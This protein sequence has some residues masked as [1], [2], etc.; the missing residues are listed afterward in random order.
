VLQ[1]QGGDLAAAS[2]S[3]RAVLALDP[4]SVM[5]RN[6]LGAVLRDLGQLDDAMTLFREALALDPAAV[7]AHNN[8]GAALRLRGNLEGAV[9]EF[10]TAL[11]LDPVNAVAL[12]NLSE[13]L[14]DLG[15]DGAAL[16]AQHRAVAAAPSDPV[17]WR[18]L[19]RALDLADDVEGAIAA[20]REALARDPDAADLH[21][22]L[23]NVLQRRLLF[24]DAASHHR[25]A[26]DLAPSHCE[27]HIGLALAL[28]RA[29]DA[30]GAL[31][32]CD[33][34]LALDRFDQEAL[35]YKALALRLGGDD[36]AADRLTDIRRFLTVLHLPAPS[37]YG[38]M[39]EFNAA[40]AAE[41]RAVRHRK[42]APAR[43]SIRGG[44]Q[45]QND[46]FA[47]TSPTI[48]AFR[49]L[50][51]ASVAAYLAGRERDP[52]AAFLAARPQRRFYKSWSVILGA[53]GYH[54]PH[55]HP[56]GCI[57]GVYYVEIPEFAGEEEAGHLEFGRP[58]I[59]MKLPALPPLT[60]VAPV[61]GRLVLFPSY[62]WH[63]T[64]PFRNR[65][66]RV[67]IAFDI[68]RPGR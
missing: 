9:A 41:L 40:L 35:A 15:R 42:W 29:G 64:R 10:Q 67:T 51:D 22:L 12:A 38:A 5:A 50:L 13:A 37:G 17:A 36:A 59:A 60:T 47:E 57:S 65:G 58:G 16:A 56:D 54:T 24:A 23:G 31:A 4:G 63:G 62:F 68:R 20:F 21:H 7:D 8:L 19:G 39:P 52:A 53:D 48:Q 46:L 44:T 1:Q 30:G 26:I 49:A 18:E 61:P 11:A 45:T 2:S 43:Q 14:R 28:L 25:R 27:L 55:M 34:A 3:Y 66:E 32:A 33:A 6:N